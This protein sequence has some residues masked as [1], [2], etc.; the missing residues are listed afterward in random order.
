MTFVL[1]V[2]TAVTAGWALAARRLERGHVRAPV[3]LVLAGVVTGVFTHSQIAV[4]LN[5]E[6]AQ[7]V[8][9]VILAVLLFVDATE[10][11]GGR[12]FGNA[13]GAAARTLLVALPLSLAAVVLLGTLLLPDLPA[14]VLLIIA[15]IIVPTDFAPAE[16]LVRDTR[17]PARVRDVLN[18]ESGY[19]DGIIS[20]VF[21]F[22]LI[23]AGSTSQA[24][25]PMQALGTA[26]PFAAKALA[27]GVALGSLL[28]WLMM[29]ADRRQWMT[30]PSRR[31]LVLVTPLLVYTV[32]VAAGGNGF[33]AA[34]V[35]GIAFRYVRQTP[36]RRHE[37]QVPDPTDFRLVEDTSSIMTMCMWF[38]F[39][40]ATVLALTDGLHAPTVLL[41][42]AALTV[43]RIAPI[44]LAFL[45]SDFTRRERLMIG[46]LGP[47]GTTS[48][49]FGLLAF[50][51]LPDGP[52]SDTA[53]Y[54]MTITVL[55]SVLLHGLA[56]TPLARRLTASASAVPPE[57]VR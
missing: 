11:P 42:L 13:P 3:V 26:V 45:G 37:T 40:N 1:I 54:A 34:F 24:H 51:A 5:S 41:C 18:V 33:V 20:P 28:A 55:A 53:L 57:K 30:G 19:N 6:I 47:R 9:E 52:S 35:C 44:L 50:N 15:C 16:T 17:I 36:A 29:T 48:I 43:A 27:V 2:I 31:I 8:A 10:L 39:G 22:A 38:F 56:S 7:H 4:T 46:A 32:T 49:V 14:V 25:T 23:L 12:L 21:L